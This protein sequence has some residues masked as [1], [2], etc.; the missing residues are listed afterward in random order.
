MLTNPHNKVLEIQPMV[1]H[2]KYQGVWFGMLI[3]LRIGYNI[4]H[5]NTQN[6]FVK[7]PREH[8]DKTYTSTPLET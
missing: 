6:M 5:R 1:Q 2:L 3:R 4:K 7:D 8:I